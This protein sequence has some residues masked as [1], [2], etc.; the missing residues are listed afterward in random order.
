MTVRQR[1]AICPRCRRE[2]LPQ[3][4]KPTWVKDVLRPSATGMVQPLDKKA[5]KIRQKKAGITRKSWLADGALKT[6]RIFLDARKASFT[7]ASEE[8]PECITIQDRC[9]P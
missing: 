6:V 9:T 2:F 7:L 8:C 1:I 5:E 4:A 3:R